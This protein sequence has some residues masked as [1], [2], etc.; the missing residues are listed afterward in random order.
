MNPKRPKVSV[1]GTGQ[2]NVSLLDDSL[3]V[4]VNTKF[5][6]FSGGVSSVVRCCVD[7]QTSQEHAVKIIDITPSDKMTHQEIQEIQEATVKETDILRKVSGQKNIN[8]T[9]TDHHNCIQ[10]QMIS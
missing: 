1:H 5:T 4:Q 2:V 10:S 7:K 9:I 3:R 8:M 6:F